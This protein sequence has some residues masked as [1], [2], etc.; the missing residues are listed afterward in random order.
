VRRA[1]IAFACIVRC[2][3]P[4]SLSAQEATPATTLKIEQTIGGLTRPV[5]F[6]TAP[7]EINRA[8]IVEQGGLVKLHSDG[9]IR[10]KPFLDIRELVSNKPEQG[11]S[12]IA[13]PPSYPKDKRV[14]AYFID[15]Q[16]DSIVGTFLPTEDDYLDVESLS[17][18]IKVVQPTPNHPGGYLAFGPD[19]FLY[20]GFNDG[21]SRGN[22][23]SPAQKTES[24]LGKLIRIDVSEQ[25]PYKVPSDNPFPSSNRSF[26]EIWALGFKNPLKFSFDRA[27]G[28]LFLGD[29][30]LQGREE[31]NIVERGKNYGWNVFEG[32][33]CLKP[34]C[35]ANRF[36]PPI[37]EYSRGEGTKVT[38]GLMYRGKRIPLLQG[39]YLFGDYDSGA[40]WIL[41]QHNGS[42]Q[43]DLLFK[44]NRHI[45][46]FGEDAEGEIYVTTLEGE[47]ARIVPSESGIESPRLPR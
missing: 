34:P 19:G 12:S 17:V 5:G 9:K 36:T 11:L 8:Y 38:G 28:Y 20:V 25:T 3:A 32:S 4:G 46:S 47:V 29:V 13:F 2:L 24:M 43:R 35:D 21:N 37:F 45:T 40:I 30:S 39:R 26:A 6:L 23:S 42:W 10:R 22:P 15:R 16:G 31:I 41:T 44:T 1:I 14:F 7:G 18:V 33:S 27:T